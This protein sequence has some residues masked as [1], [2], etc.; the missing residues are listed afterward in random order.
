MAHKLKDAIPLT[1]VNYMSKHHA[2]RDLES[3]LCI[4]CEES[5]AHLIHNEIEN[6]PYEFMD[7]T[8]DA[9]KN[10]TDAGEFL[11]KAII[12]VNSF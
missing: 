4:I 3:R 1:F 2:L 10:E 6:D 9:N 11:D 8:V 12:E 7:E 5:D